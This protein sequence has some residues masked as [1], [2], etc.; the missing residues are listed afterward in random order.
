MN[1]KTIWIVVGVLVVLV[2]GWWIFTMSGAAP[3]ANN[4][5]TATTTVQTGT[6]TG[7]QTQTGTP[8]TGTLAPGA[9]GGTLKS[10]SSPY[11]FNFQYPSVLTLETSGLG[12][13]GFTQQA[14]VG[15]AA[16]HV[17]IGTVVDRLVMSVSSEPADVG[18]CDK[19]TTQTSTAT[20]DGKIFTT[21]KVSTNKDG[22]FTDTTVYRIL[23]NQTCFELRDSV[24]YSDNA[25]LTATQAEQQRLNIQAAK[26]SIGT[27][28]QSYKVTR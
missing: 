10:F 22:N 4:G 15:V 14:A 24:T 19:S 20:I 18:S 6:Q 26:A 16:V 9:T 27:V 25:R 2:L 17:Q 23:R 21:S 7:T 1:T 13:G 5:Q 8:A 28:V 11:G 3:A 12:T